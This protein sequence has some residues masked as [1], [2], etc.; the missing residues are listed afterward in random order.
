MEWLL[1]A[2]ARAMLYSWVRLITE[3]SPESRK[4][5]TCSVEIR[6]GSLCDQLAD[7]FRLPAGLRVEKVGVPGHLPDVVCRHQ[8][9]ALDHPLRVFGDGQASEERLHRVEDQ[10][11][12]RLASCSTPALACRALN[13]P[14]PNSRDA[15]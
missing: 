8:H 14:Q 15:G 13:C 5:F 7:F 10:K 11:R 9:P 4:S 2:G 3:D 1:I 12:L 6:T